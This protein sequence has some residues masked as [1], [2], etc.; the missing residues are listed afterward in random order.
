GARQRIHA[1]HVLGDA[2][3]NA[4][5]FVAPADRAVAP[6]PDFGRDRARL[7]VAQRFV[8]AARGAAETALDVETEHTNG[9]HAATAA[10]TRPAVRSQP[11]RKSASRIERPG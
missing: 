6:A 2:A 7:H 11:R 8:E 9:A 4:E 1:R 5:R 3:G 10:R